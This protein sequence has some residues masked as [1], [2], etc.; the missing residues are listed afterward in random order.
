VTTFVDTNILVYSYDLDAGEKSKRARSVL[1]DLWRTREGVVS[2]Q[3]L[4]ELH[5]TLLR[6]LGTAVPRSRVRAA[7][8]RYGRWVTR[9]TSVDDIL[10]AIDIEQR[11]SVSFWDALIIV[12]AARA[13]ADR[14]LSEDMQ[15]GR[16]L[17]GVTIVNPFET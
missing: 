9:H 8:R 6:R 16:T 11:H 15:H 4:Q 1:A 5:V 13:G 7:V 12:A 17:A 2:T 3:V 10:E 14:L